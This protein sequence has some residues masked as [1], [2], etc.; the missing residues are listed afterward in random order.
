MEVDQAAFQVQMDCHQRNVSSNRL[1]PN[2]HYQAKLNKMVS[3]PPSLRTH[4]VTTTSVMSHTIAALSNTSE[5]FRP[6]SISTIPKALH[7]EDKPAL[8]AST[9]H[10]ES[11]H[12]KTSMSMN[13]EPTDCVLRFWAELDQE[14]QQ[15]VVSIITLEFGG[16]NNIPHTKVPKLRKYWSAIYV[17]QLFS[18]STSLF[19]KKLLQ[20]PKLSATSDRDS[21]RQQGM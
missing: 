6:F 18:L 17:Q 8:S 1:L 10:I 4:S 5:I 11:E 19:Q 16:S 9:G 13:P 14:E 20:K 7:E 2:S 21:D 3:S 12:D 15:S